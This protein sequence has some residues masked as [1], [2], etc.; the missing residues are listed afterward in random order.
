M[1]LTDG[2]NTEDCEDSV[3]LIAMPLQDTLRPDQL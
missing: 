3:L 2:V 1:Y